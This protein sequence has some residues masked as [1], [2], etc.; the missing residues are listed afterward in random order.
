MERIFSILTW[1]ASAITMY[2]NV[3]YFFCIVGRGLY[4]DYGLESFMLPLIFINNILWIGYGFTKPKKDWPL[5]IANTSEI[6][7]ILLLFILLHFS[8]II[9]C[10]FISKN[11]FIIVFFGINSTTQRESIH[12]RCVFLR[13]HLQEKTIFF[14]LW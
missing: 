6:I 4:F 2:I 9:F 13:N 12:F 7:I 10:I 8:D 14:Y 5:I 3:S 1:L 11:V